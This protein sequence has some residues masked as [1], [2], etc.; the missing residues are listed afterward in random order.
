MWI[1]GNN[2]NKPRKENVEV[3]ECVLSFGAESFV[4]QFSIKHFKD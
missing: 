4:F 1:F 3:R 2:L